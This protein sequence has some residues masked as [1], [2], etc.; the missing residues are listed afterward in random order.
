MAMALE[1]IRILDL[2]ANAPSRYCTQVL[3]ENVS[4]RRRLVI[5]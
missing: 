1:G 3:G 4:K 5:Q 2:T